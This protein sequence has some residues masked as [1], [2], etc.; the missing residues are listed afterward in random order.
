LRC[1]P[2][3]RSVGTS[4]ARM[5]RASSTNDATAADPRAVACLRAAGSYRKFDP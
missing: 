5:V 1:R 4:C 2:A 3:A